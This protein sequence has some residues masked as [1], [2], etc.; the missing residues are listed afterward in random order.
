MKKDAFIHF[1]AG[2]LLVFSAV[3]LVKC[4]SPA[5]DQAL[6]AEENTE[7]A[8]TSTAPPS[9]DM[10]MHDEAMPMLNEV[11]MDPKAAVTPSQKM[12]SKPKPVTSKPKVSEQKSEIESPS[13]VLPPTKT[14]DVPPPV[15]ATTP[16]A[17]VKPAPVSIPKS[18]T[19]KHV[20]FSLKSTKAVIKGSSSLHAWESNITKVE[21]NGSFETK[22]DALVAV[23]DVEIKIPVTSIKSKEGKRMDNKTYDTFQ[24]DKN[25]YIVFKLSKATVKI[26]ASNVVSIEAPGKLTM[27]GNTQSVSLSATGKK[28]SNG[29]LQLSVSHK[30]KMTDYKMEPP[31]MLLGTIKVGDE[32]T[33]EFDFVLTQSSD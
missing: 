26:N 16:E 28:L 22:D 23:K 9:M 7:I 2:V 19:V 8:D 18:P 4:H 15:S 3:S 33:V 31:V 20:A 1:L 12:A 29:D 24:A 11:D 5:G 21:G 32:I 25:P 13:V 6:V 14:S 27:A 17:K 10:V 30:L